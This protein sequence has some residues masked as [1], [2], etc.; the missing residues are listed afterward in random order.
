MWFIQPWPTMS[1]LDRHGST[2]LSLYHH[3]H[4][5]GRLNGKPI[6]IPAN[7]T[8]FEPSKAHYNETSLYDE[9][10]S[11]GENSITSLIGTPLP[12]WKDIKDDSKISLK[13][14]FWSKRKYKEESNSKSQPQCEQTWLLNGSIYCY[15]TWHVRL[16][17]LKQKV[18]RPNKA[19]RILIAVFKRERI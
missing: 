10:I 17:C 11:Y 14:I 13:E 7:L 12:N 5:K 3:W 9:L 6:N 18:P 15:L 19:S 8:P 4:A 16:S 2:N 1:C